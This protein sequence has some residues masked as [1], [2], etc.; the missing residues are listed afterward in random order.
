[1]KDVVREEDGENCNRLGSKYRD[2]RWVGR[3]GPEVSR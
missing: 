2:Q 1:M 3:L